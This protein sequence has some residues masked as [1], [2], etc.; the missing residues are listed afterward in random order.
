MHPLWAR[1][2]FT[3]HTYSCCQHCQPN[4]QQTYY[5]AKLQTLL[6]KPRPSV[7]FILKVTVRFTLAQATKVRVGGGHISILSLTSLLDGG[8]WSSRTGPVTPR[9]RHTVPTAQEAGW[10]P[11]PV[12]AGAGNL[13]PTGIRSPHGPARSKLQ[14]LLSYPG[15]RTL[16]C[17]GHNYSLVFRSYMIW[18]NN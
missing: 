11:G 8:G 4:Q 18:K 1:Y 3:A 17:I 5:S 9:E 12:W 2:S 13:T 16:L 6:S 10:A 15:P 14:Y 7:D